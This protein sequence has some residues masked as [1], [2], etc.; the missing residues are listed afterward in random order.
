LV[1]FSQHRHG[2][3]SIIHVC[4]Y[5]KLAVRDFGASEYSGRDVEKTNPFD[6]RLIR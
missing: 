2:K 3:S 6:S 4:R 5:L 1:G